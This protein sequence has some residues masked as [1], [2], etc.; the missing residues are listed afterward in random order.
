MKLFKCQHCEQMLYFENTTC[1]RCSHRLGFIPEIMNLSALEPQG[2][3]SQGQ[4]SQG[5][6]WRALAVDKKLYRF[7]ANT[8]FDVCNWMIEAE[9]TDRYCAACRHNRTVPDTGVADNVGAWRKIE[10]AKHRLFYTLMKLNL[11]LD[12]CNP[13]GSTRL[14]FDFLASPAQAGGS[15]VMTGHDNG[16]I[17]LALEEADD[18]EREKRRTQMHEPY[19]TL[20]GHFRHEVGHYFWDVLVRDGGLIEPCRQIFGDER[21]DYG[22]G[23]QTYYANGAPPNW[24]DNFISAYATSHPWEDFAETW[25]HYLHIV[26]TLEMARALGMY[27]HPRLARPGELDAQVDFDPYTVRDPSPLIQT[28][29]PLSN[30]LN[31][32]NRTMGLL[33]IYPF[34]LSPPVVEK[35]SAIHHLVHGNPLSVKAEQAA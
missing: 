27:V 31:S 10:I 30:A 6:V 18:A 22:A 16:L 13:D 5:D 32:L 12:K 34:V 14:A 11:P 25:A 26:D 33:D 28:W 35:L 9:K 2:Q 23:L 20:L 21:M 15:R 24:Q 4:A 19:R 17:T 8:A 1:E 3:A 7:C 29:V